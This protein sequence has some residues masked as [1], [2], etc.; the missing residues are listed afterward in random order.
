MFEEQI[1]TSTISQHL[2]DNDRILSLFSFSLS[3][4]LVRLGFELR[5]SHIKVCILPL[6]PLFQSILLV[7]LEIRSCELFA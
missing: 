6:E 2:L 3:F 1:L 5:A 4:F 7:I